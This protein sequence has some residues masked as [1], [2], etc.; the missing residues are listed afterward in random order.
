MGAARDGFIDEDGYRALDALNELRESF[1]FRHREDIYTVC[2]WPPLRVTRANPTGLW[3]GP[4]PRGAP[5]S[6]SATFW[7]KLRPA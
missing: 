7:P 1:G 3:S 5:D 6:N 4:R 2:D